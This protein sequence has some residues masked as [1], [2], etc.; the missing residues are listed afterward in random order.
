MFRNVTKCLEVFQNSL[1]RTGIIRFPMQLALLLVP[2]Y[3]PLLLSY[4]PVTHS[5]LHIRELGH[6]LVV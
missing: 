6:R 5:A 4:Q 3:P 1:V 2:L